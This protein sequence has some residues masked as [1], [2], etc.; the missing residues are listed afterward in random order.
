MTEFAEIEK[1]IL[2][3]GWKW[4][5]LYNPIV[6]IQKYHLNL[7]L[8]KIFIAKIIKVFKINMPFTLYCMNFTNTKGTT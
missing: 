7:F 3:F 8:I 6:L 2:K 4:K 1:I 5:S